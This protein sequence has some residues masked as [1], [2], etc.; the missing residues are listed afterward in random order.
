LE[1]LRNEEVEIREHER[2]TKQA[3]VKAGACYLKWKNPPKAKD[4]KPVF[5]FRK[6]LLRQDRQDR[7]DYKKS[8]DKAGESSEKLS[9]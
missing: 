2:H 9:S 4:E 7:P 5:S 1:S 3:R 8:F 6:V